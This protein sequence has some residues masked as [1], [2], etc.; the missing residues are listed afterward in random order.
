MWELLITPSSYSP[1]IKAEFTVMYRFNEADDNNRL[2]KYYFD[3]I[4]YQVTMLI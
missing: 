3:I 4:D 1:T 2:Y